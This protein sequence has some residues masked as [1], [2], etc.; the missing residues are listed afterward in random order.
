[1]ASF[2]HIVLLLLLS[3]TYSS[4]DNPT[5]YC[6]PN[7]VISSSSQ[8]SANI[9]H[10]LADIITKFLQGDTFVEASYG[11]NKDTIY[12]LAQ[13]RGDLSSKDCLD[14]IQDAAKQVRKLC[15][16]QSDARIWYDYCFLRHSQDKFFGNVDTFPGIL[17]KNTENVTNPVMFNKELG[18]IFDKIDSKAVKPSSGGLGKDQKK[19]TNFETLYALVQC[20]RDLSPLSCGQCLAQAIQ[21]FEGF[22]SNSIGC[23]VLYSSCYVRY[24]LYPFFF[25]LEGQNSKNKGHYTRKLVPNHH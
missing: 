12:G 11:N 22:C 15:P 20:T 4:A 7:T 5:E 19:L 23:R 8:I 1:M 9:D 6:N 13:C 3:I 25:P 10:L 18:N 14:C 2:F 24:E 17:Y 21:N 16:T